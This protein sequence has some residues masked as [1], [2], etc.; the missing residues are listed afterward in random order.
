MYLYLGEEDNFE[1]LP[2]LLFQRFGRPSLV[3]QLELTPDRKL[4]QEDAAKV[5]ANLQAQ[6]FHLQLPPDLKPHLYQGE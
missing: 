1:A 5:L 3:M 6:G 4:A 2:P